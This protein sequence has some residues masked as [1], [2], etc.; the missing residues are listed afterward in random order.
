MLYFAPRQAWPQTFTGAVDGTIT[1]SSGA[2]IT[3]AKVA[4]RN[5]QTDEQRTSVA[6]ERG[7]FIFP[8]VTPGT[9]ELV[10]E[11]PGFKRAIRGNVLVEVH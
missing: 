11:A 8:A 10:M 2:L 6:N 7:Q 5:L 3:G 1:D 9:Y 4:L